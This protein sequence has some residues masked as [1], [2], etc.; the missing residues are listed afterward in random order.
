MLLS[1]WRAPLENGVLAKLLR[2]QEILTTGKLGDWDLRSA[3]ITFLNRA[4]YLTQDGR[5]LEY[6]RRTGQDL[7]VPRVGQSFWPEEHLQPELAMD[8]VGHW[9]IHD[10]PVPM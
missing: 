2:G 6:L 8:V 5:W 9:N 4:A 7:S 1:G 3:S 10:M